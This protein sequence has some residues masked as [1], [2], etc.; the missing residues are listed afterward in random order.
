[1]SNKMVAYYLMQILVGPNAFYINNKAADNMVKKR[2]GGIK[3]NDNQML[4]FAI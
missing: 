4:L 3:K 1:M 2:V